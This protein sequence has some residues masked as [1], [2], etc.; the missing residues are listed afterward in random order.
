MIFLLFFVRHVKVTN[1]IT[2]DIL[3]TNTNELIGHLQR[4]LKRKRQ[5]RDW[6]PRKSQFL[7]AKS[8]IEND[9][10][11]ILEISGRKSVRKVIVVAITGENAS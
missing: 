7:F 11:K 10:I 6:Y 4:G 5:K 3:N 2:Q 1:K 8:K 9:G